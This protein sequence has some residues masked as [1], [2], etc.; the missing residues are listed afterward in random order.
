MVEA[1]DAGLAKFDILSQRGLGK[2]RDAVNIIE[3]N[4]KEK[5]DIH[6]VKRFMRDQQVSDN[7]N[8]QS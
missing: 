4:K 6:D 5:I 7:L 1:E 3:Q 8:M 2:V